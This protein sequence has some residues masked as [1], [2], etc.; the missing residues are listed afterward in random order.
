MPS[1]RLPRIISPNPWTWALGSWLHSILFFSRTHQGQ[2]LKVKKIKLLDRYSAMAARAGIG[3]I[4]GIPKGG[5]PTD[6]MQV[7]F[8]ILDMYACS[9][10]RS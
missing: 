1:E 10:L 6:E 3:L 8:V 9:G 7:E 2:D 5:R 4:F